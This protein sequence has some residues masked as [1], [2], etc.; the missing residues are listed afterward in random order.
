MDSMRIESELMTTILSKMIT[1]ALRKNG[2][3]I[4]V[5]LHGVNVQKT[6]GGYHI[7]AGAGCDID[8]NDILAMTRKFLG[9]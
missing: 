8:E 4:D 5:Q 1:K 2:I 3:D 7:E 9:V 6:E